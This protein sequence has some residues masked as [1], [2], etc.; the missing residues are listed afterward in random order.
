MV[1]SVG[2]RIVVA[3]AFELAPGLFLLRKG[4]EWADR[5]V[6]P[7]PE[8][9]AYIEYTALLSI[10]LTLLGYYFVIYGGAGVLGGLVGLAFA[11]EFTR[12]LALRNE[13]H[14]VAMLAAGAFLVVLGRRAA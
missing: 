5:L 4:P 13:I 8:G 11:D 6:P 2:V 14:S 3:A 1:T 7:G 9:Q 10:G 12:S